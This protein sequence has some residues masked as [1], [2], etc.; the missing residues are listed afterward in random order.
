MLG[1]EDK[2]LAVRSSVLDNLSSESCNSK[3]IVSRLQETLQLDHASLQHPDHET[4]KWIQCLAREARHSG[5]LDVVKYLR[6]ITPAGTTGEYSFCFGLF[7]FGPAPGG[8]A[9]ST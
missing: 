9:S 1:N 6:E 3:E 5:R 8:V 2:A 4:K 7:F